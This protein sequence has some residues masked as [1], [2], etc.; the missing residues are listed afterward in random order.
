M[1]VLTTDSGARRGVGQNRADNG[2][3]TATGS[4]GL[5]VLAGVGRRLYPLLAI[6]IV[7]AIW[8]FAVHTFKIPALILPAPTAIFVDLWQQREMYFIF[9]VPTFVEVVLGFVVA[10]IAGILLAIAVS[11]SGFMRRTLYPLLISSQM[12]PKIAIAPLLIIWFGTGLE[13]KTLIALLIAFFPIMVATMVG[14]AAVD[15]D[16]VRLFRSMGAGPVRTFIKLR[17]PA[18]LPN[19]FAG[20][21]LGMTMALVGAIVAEF[22]ASNKGLGYYLIY[23]N[24]M[25]DT[26]GVFAALFLLT[27]MGVALYYMVEFAE[28]LFV[29]DAL[30][31]GADPGQATM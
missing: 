25:L 9:T 30:S 16:M 2:P 28:R 27:V 13:A 11:F 20:L 8:E 1:T 10:A 12:V 3:G 21:K 29:L 26:T 6:F 23:A 31:R 22:V 14:L 15:P 4:T 18:A 17:L 5:A 19:V 7:F 24:G